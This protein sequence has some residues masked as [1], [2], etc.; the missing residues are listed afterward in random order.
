MKRSLKPN[1]RHIHTVVMIRHGESTWNLERRFTGWCDVPLTKRGELDAK[2]AGIL[3]GER[4]LKFDV[5]FTSN[6]ERAWRSCAIALSACGQSNTEIIRS[7]KLNERHYGALQGHYKDAPELVEAFGEEK[8]IA[9]RKSFHSAPPSLYDEDVLRRLGPNSLKISTEFLNQ[10]YIDQKKFN[11]FSNIL[12]QRSRYENS[13]T[14][15]TPNSSSSSSSNALFDDSFPYP[16]TESLQ[17]CQVRAFG[18]WKEVIAPRLLEGQ[19]VLIVAHANTIR[20]LVKAVDNIDDGMIAHLKIPNGVPL[21][22]TMDEQLNPHVDDD[23]NN[24]NAND[25]G[26][27]A[28]YLVSARNHGRMM[29]YERC[30]RKKLRSLF[31]YLDTDNDNRITPECLLRGLNRLQSY[32]TGDEDQGRQEGVI[33]EGY[34]YQIS[35]DFN[36]SNNNN[37]IRLQRH[38]DMCEYEVEELIRCVPKADS[39]GQ[40]TLQDFLA[41]EETVLS[42]LT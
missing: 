38:A 2:D 30:V 42:K 14:L 23:Y 16:S 5:A 37:A 41:A 7:W 1:I 4:G 25:L 17:Q 20:A 28:K 24:E 21:V 31:E 6:L 40:I 19:R 12:H 33:G 11:H 29:A 27:Q 22:Y 32:A 18:Y 15:Y 8:V 13:S 35:G 9:W 26:F 34:D 3:M 39:S 10:N 36:N